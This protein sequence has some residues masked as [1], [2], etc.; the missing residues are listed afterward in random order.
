MNRQVFLHT[1][2]LSLGLCV[3]LLVG[4]VSGASSYTLGADDVIS[5]TIFAGGEKQVEV[6]VSIS[7]QG[8]INAPFVGP[9]KAAGISTSDLEE[10]LLA[11]LKKDY[12]VDPQVHIQVQEYQSLRYSISGAVEKPGKFSM[13][14]ATTLMELIAKA[15]GATKERGSVAYIMRDNGA[16]KANTEPI[17]VNLTKLL[18]EGDMSHNIQLQSGDSIYIPLA[19]GLN[20]NDS[21]VFVSGRVKKP[22]SYEFQPG[23]TALSVC[24][25]AGGF[26]EFAAPNRATI[27]RVDG[28]KQEVI[29]IDLED[30]VEGKIADVPLKAGDRL[31]IPESWL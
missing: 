17:K 31:N 26:D 11:S 3:T 30:V 24:I 4:Q 10:R 13:Q 18:D 1:L 16:E 9:T 20:Q 29:K 14:S 8:L 12:F 21:M 19:K 7:G 22:G 15:E 25:M 6:N 2:L 28:E 23:L 5:V 27:V